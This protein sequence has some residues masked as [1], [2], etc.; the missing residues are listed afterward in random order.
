[1]D[2]T[3][4]CSRSEDEEEIFT[5]EVGFFDTI[6]DIKRSLQARRGWPAAAISL[7]HNGVALAGDGEDSAAGAEVYGIVEG[8]VIRVDLAADAADCTQQKQKERGGGGG[9]GEAMVRVKVVTRCGRW[10]AEVAVGARRPVA[11]LRR[12]LEERGFPVPRDGGGYFFIH[13]QSVM[14]E[15]RSFEWHGVAAGDEVVV[16]EGSNWYLI[17]TAT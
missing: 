10:R 14:D 13:R 5:M 2:V 17:G 3:F 16:F 11:A 8:S 7:S 15:E 9:G 4:V 6:D 1:M 12:E